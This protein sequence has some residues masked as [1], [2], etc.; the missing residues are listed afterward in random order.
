MYDYGTADDNRDHYGVVS[1]Q[2]VI[3]YQVV[4][5]ACCV[6]MCVYVW[7][8]ERENG[9]GEKVHVMSCW[10]CMY[11]PPS[12]QPYPPP[13]NVSE[14][15]VKTAL[16][17]GGQDWLADPTD[18]ADLLPKIKD[19]VF[20]H[21]NITYYE[22]LDFIWGLDAATEIYDEIISLIKTML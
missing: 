22:H 15:T 7:E 21:K 16:F 11:P 12:T 19:V 8:R 3:A 4:V 14:L 2:S 6:C 17:T 20:Y 9:G 10:P 18:V 1:G 13:Y 5:Y